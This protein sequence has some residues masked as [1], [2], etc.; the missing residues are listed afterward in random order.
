MTAGCRISLRHRR[1]TV[2]LWIG[3]A[4]GV[5]NTVL[6]QEKKYLINLSE[7]ARYDHY[8]AQLLLP[9]LNNGGQ[10]YRVRSLYF[11]TLDEDDYQERQDGVEI[12]RKIRLRFYTPSDQT[13]KLEIKQKQG[14]QQLKRSLIVSRQDAIRFSQAD[15]SP[16][17]RYADPLAAEL[18]AVMNMRCYRPK[19]IVQYRRKAYLTKEVETRITFDHSIQATESNLDFFSENLNLYPVFDSY[20]VILEV[21]YNNFLL[22]YLKEMLQQVNRSELSVSKYSLSRSIGLHYLF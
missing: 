11:D 1:N 20:N 14:N 4:G 13:I 17:L 22:S 6:R 12:R 21:K 3:E 9:D 2:F 18:Y 8:L 15:Y 5:M 19:A 10:G 16:L 7:F